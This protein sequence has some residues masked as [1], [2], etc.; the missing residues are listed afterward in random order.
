MWTVL[1]HRCQRNGYNA[2][3]VNKI[4][5]VNTYLLSWKGKEAPG[6]AWSVGCSRSPSQTAAVERRDYLSSLRHIKDDLQAELPLIS[7]LFGT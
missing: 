1:H 2:G 4:S 3:V 6:I 5:K 7:G